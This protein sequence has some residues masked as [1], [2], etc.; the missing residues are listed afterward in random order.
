VRDGGWLRPLLT[1]VALVGASALLDRPLDDYASA[2]GTNP[3]AKA[4]QDIGNAMPFIG[5]GLAGASWLAER[6]SVQGDIA[7]SA[8]LASTSA[9]VAAAGLKYA[10]DRARPT[11]NL[12]PASFG[13]KQPRS[14]S[15]FPSIHTALAYRRGRSHERVACVEPRALVLGQ[16]GRRGPRLRDR[17]R[18][19]PD[20]RESRR[21]RGAR[22]SV[23][24]GSIMWSRKL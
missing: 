8:L 13:D 5:F 3:S 16:C 22:L 10:V 17:R 11:D 18:H 15:S 12:G 19:V 21:E 14:D 20:E 6:G 1:S 2:H 7:Y 24:R 23:G 4:L 9:F